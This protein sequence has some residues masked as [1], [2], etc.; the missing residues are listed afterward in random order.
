[1]TAPVVKGAAYVLVHTPDM[2]MHYGTT[3]ALEHEA[4]PE[5]EFLKEASRVCKKL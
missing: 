3:C 1:M 2:I 4:N 5:S